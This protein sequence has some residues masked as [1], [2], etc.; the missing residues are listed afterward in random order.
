MLIFGL[1]TPPQDPDPQ[2]DFELHLYFVKIY[3]AFSQVV[4]GSEP[5]GA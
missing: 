2:Q 5:V 3:I 4:Q 1:P